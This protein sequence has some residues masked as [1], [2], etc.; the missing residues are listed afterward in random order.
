MFFCRILKMRPLKII[1]YILI[2]IVLGSCNRSTKLNNSIQSTKKGNSID[3]VLVK[4]EN[5]IDKS[6]IDFYSKSYTY[7]WVTEND[8]LDFNIGLTE[9]VSDSSVQIRFSHNKPVLFLTAIEKL[10]DCLPMIVQDFDMLKLKL[11]YF[12]SPILYKDLTIE[13]SKS[14]EV[15]FNNKRIKYH[16]LNEFLMNSWLEEKVSGFLTQF[17]KTTKRYVI[18]KFQLLDKKYYKNFIPDINVSDYPSFSIHGMG[19]SLILN[20]N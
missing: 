8:T 3:T 5:T 6:L 17:N 10:N 4:V 19:V 1:L 2:F 11:F 12:K 15:Q 7:Y 14:Y 9:H 16:R 18:E 20:E 13:L